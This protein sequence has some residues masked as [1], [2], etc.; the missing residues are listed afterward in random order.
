MS[1]AIVVNNGV[2]HP[3]EGECIAIALSAGVAANLDCSAFASDGD[4][5]SI[6]NASTTVCG[7]KFSA[8]AT[9]NIDTAA[10]SGAQACGRIAIQGVTRGYIP[11]GCPHLHLVT[12]GTGYVY[13]SVTSV[14]R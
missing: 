3:V 13:V 11:Y 7:Y 9:P 14:A 12:A 6:H 1:S 8:S 5:I 4:M 10:T 2:Q